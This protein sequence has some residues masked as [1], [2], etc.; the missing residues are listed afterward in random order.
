M[1]GVHV[2]VPARL[3]ACPQVAQQVVAAMFW[4]AVAVGSDRRALMFCL[5]MRPP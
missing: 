1:D 3:P 2:R 5:T 4:L